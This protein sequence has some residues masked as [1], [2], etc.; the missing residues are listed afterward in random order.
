[1]K[2][3]VLTVIIIT[4]FVFSMLL[5]GAIGVFAEDEQAKLRISGLKNDGTVEHIKSYEN[6]VDGWNE[7][8]KLACDGDDL[9]DRGYVRVVVDLLDDWIAKDGEFS[10]SGKG[11]NWDAIYIPDDAKLTFN[12][13]G[14]TIDRGLEEYQY[15][16]EVMYIDEDADVIINGGANANDETIGIITGGFSCN[17][18]GGIHIN[19]DAKVTLNNVGITGNETEDDDGAGIAL[20]GG[21]KLVMNGGYVS[22]NFMTFMIISSTLAN[23]GGGIYCED[24]KLE[25][26]NV[27]FSGNES[28]KH[29][30]GSA[31][32]AIDSDVKINGCTFK[33]NSVSSI[34]DSIIHLKDSHVEITDSIVEGNGMPDKTYVEDDKNVD[35]KALYVV[36]CDSFVM[37]NCKLIGNNTHEV[38]SIFRTDFTFSNCEI[39]DNKGIAM[40]AFAFY[41][42]EGTIEKCSFNGNNTAGIYGSS[43]DAVGYDVVIKDCDIGD[44]TFNHKDNFI[45]KTTPESKLASI[46]SNGSLS[47]VIAIISMG[48]SIVCAMTIILE[49]KRRDEKR[50]ESEEGDDKDSAASVS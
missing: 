37:D 9:K 6:I 38:I 47:N 41:F 11:F 29:C 16:G 19:D 3:R 8:V 50:L 33:N 17:G 39:K 7:A 21:A 40:Y 48:V 30:H 14:H 4:S 15:N 42:G 10:N 12:L 24:S 28:K 32:Y 31:L 5:I 43:L 22:D 26:N 23:Y 2:K 44:S 45:F 36:E 18:A 49:K 34:A 27:S 20:Y 25:L 35:Y 13:H 46:F 1:M